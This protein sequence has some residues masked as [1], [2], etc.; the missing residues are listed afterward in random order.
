MH[1][2]RQTQDTK[3]LCVS[4]DL[5]LLVLALIAFYIKHFLADFLLQTE[6][7]AR[8]KE[9]A[10][11]WQAPLSAH[12]GC[13]A[14]LTVGIILWF[15]ASLWW[16]GPVD[17]LVHAA[18]DRSKG[19]VLRGAGVS[20]GST[21]WWSIFGIDQTMHHLTHLVYSVMIVLAASAVTLTR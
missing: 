12:A 13:H 14:V 8:G 21:M 11:D 20:Q 10:R 17:F 5:S 6:W 1:A 7:M 16:L 2:L 4:A 3:G 9:R 15:N 19:L 18:I